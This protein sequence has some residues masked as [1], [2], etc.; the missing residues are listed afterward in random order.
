MLTKTIRPTA[1]VIVLLTPLATAR[2][3]W[4]GGIGVLGDSHS[5]EY[6]FYPPHR[7]TAR[8]WVEILVA[9]RALNFGRFSPVSRGEPRNQGYEY[10]WARSDATTDDLIATGQHVGLAAQVARGEVSLV[11][12]AI[13]GNDFINAMKTPDPVATFQEVGRRAEANL[14]LAVATVLRAHQDV[15][16]VIS[17]VADIRDLPE[18][19]VPLKAG[20]LPR[21]SADAATATIRRYNARIR[22]LAAGQ[23]RVAVLD[24]FL[25]SQ[26]SDRISPE[27]LPV[28]GHSIARS[29]PS[30]APDHLFLGDVRHLGT[31]GQGL[32]AELVVATINAKFAAGVPPLTQ[33]EIFEF[34]ETVAQGPTPRSDPRKP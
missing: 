11:V 33:R 15:K 10:N 2:A 8:N 23:P 29:G 6:Q 20:R 13:G 25:V 30:D 22:A 26:A 7:S 24:F 17:T 1:L 4:R 31:V 3:E 28:A 18:F 9:S 12:V 5:D 21:A 14:A 32:L 34:A 19:R 16:M 27:S